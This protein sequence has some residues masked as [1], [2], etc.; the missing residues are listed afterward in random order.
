MLHTKCTR[1]YSSRSSGG[2]L[3]VWRIRR[4]CELIHRPIPC[5]RQQLKM[6]NFVVNESLNNC[7]GQ[8]RSLILSCV[9]WVLKTS[10]SPE[11]FKRTYSECYFGIINGQ[12]VV[13]CKETLRFPKNN[14]NKQTKFRRDS[15][16]DKY[17]SFVISFIQKNIRT[18]L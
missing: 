18:P 14:N 2:F 7:R 15:R 1:F 12:S 13:S 16:S 10:Q 6:T 17:H 9:N 8:T 4:C 11:R 3:C 5:D